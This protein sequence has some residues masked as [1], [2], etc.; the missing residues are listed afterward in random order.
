MVK[1]RKPPKYLSTITPSEVQDKQPKLSESR[2]SDITTISFRHVVVGENYCLSLCGRK[3][4]KAYKDLLR[5][6]TSIE[7]SAVLRS[8]TK[9]KSKKTGFHY[10]SFKDSDLRV[11]RPGTLSVDLTIS[12]IRASG[13]W[14]LYGAYCEGVYYVLWFDTKHSIAKGS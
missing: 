8:S 6:L 12:S 14:R 11:A 7:W 13:K 2:I 4:V 1:P 5:R 3:E 10:E 9:D